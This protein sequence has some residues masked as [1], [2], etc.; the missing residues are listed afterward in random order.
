MVDRLRHRGP[1]GSGVW[2]EPACG[3]ALGHTRLKV[4]DL[5]PA[6]GQ[7][8]IAP[9]RAATVRVQ[10]SQDSI[11]LIYN[12]EIYNFAA[13]R[14]ELIRDG[15]SFS[16][17]GDTA[18]LF[19]L[20]RRDPDL[21]FLPRLNGMFAF[22]LWDG[23]DK[24]LS[25]VR[26][27]T[28]VKPLLYAE[29][30]GG[31]VFG[32]EMRA[33]RPALTTLSIDP[34]AVMQLLT[35]GF[36]L[37][38]RTIFREVW[39]LEPGHLLRWRDGRV[40]V[41]RWRPDPPPPVMCDFEEARQRL[42]ETVRAAVVERLMADVPVGVFLSG[43]IDS[44]IVTAMAAQHGAGT[45]RT[46]SIGFPGEP[47]FDE[48]PYARAVAERYA[49]DHTE[50]PLSLDDVRA[51]IPDVLDHLSEPFADSSA[52]PTWAVS[53]LARQHVTVAL[54]G[55]GADELFAG[56][57]RYLA[58]RLYKRFAWLAYT[59]L[60]SPMRG[61]I[62]RLPV[63]RET[64]LG[65]KISQLKRAIRSIDRSR[66]R[67]YAQWM[68]IT[69]DAALRRLVHLDIAPT[70]ARIENDL[71]QHR[72]EP[73]DSDDLNAHLHTEW[74]TSLPDDMLTKVDLM[75]MAHG[76]EVRSPFLDFRVVDLVSPWPSDWKLHGW[77]KKH[78]LIET[79]RDDLP[80][81]LHDRP[82]QGFEVPVGPWLRG[83]LYSMARE[84]IEEDAA[85]C[86]PMLSREG[87][88]S[89]IEQ[90]RDGRADHTST[91]W[92]LVALLSWRRRHAPSVEVA[93][94]NP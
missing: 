3:V 33:L 60:Y 61:L 21:G 90:H 11:A 1:D 62:E 53:R 77:R 88:I 63:R 66:P 67:R 82:K 28:G 48:S 9:I 80:T 58:A 34:H 41:R 38:P 35:L 87:A 81:M 89:L 76:L 46:F 40:E 10:S 45:I 4:I 17:T 31:I 54:S 12:G 5:T 36:I 65:S 70:V 51:V 2:S 83:Q 59:P 78:L 85:F 92:S 72:G 37:A 57:R 42:R 14:E 25:L 7:P 71:W 44:S 16:S 93:P 75:S 20:C 29:V 23:G 18:V 68:R 32:S 43:G 79:F 73:R 52:L 50:I 49:T 27:R 47:A 64:R 24:T 56:Y 8:M 22:A 26:D 6:A 55:D 69:D 39:R 19:E 15:A 30:D 13:L 74:T 91:L 94:V 84:L 86:G